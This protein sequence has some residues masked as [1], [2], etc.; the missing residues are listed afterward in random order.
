MKRDLRKSTTAKSKE[1]NERLK[2]REVKSRQ[3]QSHHLLKVA[4]SRKASIYEALELLSVVESE[5]GSDSE[6]EVAG[7]QEDEYWYDTSNIELSLSATSPVIPPPIEDQDP[8]TW[9]N[10]NQFFPVGCI[11]SPAIPFSPVQG[12]SGQ[13]REPTISESE[14][15]PPFLSSGSIIMDEQAVNRKI[16]QIKGLAEGVLML[17]ERF[18]PETVTILDKDYYRT[19]LSSIFDK[20]TEF[21]T[22]VNTLKESLDDTKEYHKAAST[23][24]TTLYTNLKAKVIANETEVKRQM[25]KLVTESDSSRSDRSVEIEQEKLKLKVSNAKIKFDSLKKEVAKITDISSMSDHEVRESV[26]TTKEWKKELKSLQDLKEKLDVDMV[27]II[28]DDEVKNSYNEAY[29]DMVKIVTD[30]MS[31]LLLADKDL[32]LYSLADSKTKGTIQYPDSFGGKMGEDVFKFIKEFKEAVIADHVRKADE[33]KTLIKY[34]KGDAKA[35]IGQ[36]HKTLESALQQLEDNY[37]SPRLIVEKYVRDYE[38][39]FGNI[40]QWGKHGSKE[41]VDAINKTTDFI[42]NLEDL[43]TNHPGHLKGEIYSKQTLLLLTKGMPHDYTKRLNETCGHKDPYEDWFSA[44]FDI[45]EDCKCTNLSALSTGIGASKVMKDD[46]HGTNKA[47]QLSHNGHDCIKSSQCKDRWDFLGCVQLYKLIQVSER[48]A[49]LRERRACF[50]CGKSPFSVKVG[51]MHLCSWKNGKMS[52][53][54][55]GKHSSGGRCYKAA[56]MCAD[57]KDNASDVLLDWLQAQRIKFTVNMIMVSQNLGTP[58][59]YYDDLK[60]K[61]EQQEN[62]VVKSR[63]SVQNRESLQSGKSSLMM[64][65]EEIYE[66][67][68]QDMRLMRSSAKVSKIPDG[69]AIFIFCVVAGLN[70][71]VMAFIDC[72]ANCFLAKEGIPES[73][74]ISVKLSNGP[75]PLSVAGGSTTYASAEYASLLPLANGNYQAVRG[76]TLRKVTGNMPELRLS[77]AFDQIKQE[78]SNNRRIQ[79]LQVPTVIG[80]EVHMI[81]GIRY[82]S[83][84]PQ[85]VHTFPSGLTIFESKLQPAEPGA[86]ACV[87]GPVS[88]L[89]SLC[90]TI[91]TSSTLS[92]MANLIQNTGQH[93]RIDLFPVNNSGFDVSDSDDSS[94]MS[95]SDCGS[96][97][98]QSEMEKFMRLQDAG[99]DSTFKCPTCRN[100][101]SCLKGAGKE[102]LSMK[103]EYQQKIIEDSVWIDDEV[104]QAVARLAFT[105]D[106]TEGLTDNEYI[107]VRR[108][109]DVC[110]KYGGDSS[111]KDM[112]T[113]GFE[114]L[115]NRGHIL[116]Y[117]NLSDLDQKLVD[118]PGYYIPWDIAF[119]QDSMSTPA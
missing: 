55:L 107:A 84:Y 14:L 24:V 52:A 81:L 94:S 40:R 17:I 33:I 65:N 15:D 7:E 68:T 38:K 76:L 48:E 42:R 12:T 61:L 54:C 34:L 105:T 32:G 116:L 59:N 36:H 70:N 13:L 87:G 108:L 74:F 50:K 63:L 66:F 110:R 71:P 53:R 62:S 85:V 58:S 27:S 60:S 73:E 86:L 101:K 72:G 57:H 98:I 37:G 97:L 64:D 25:V 10:S 114:K 117:D 23:N 28:V 83:I 19:E 11:T 21:Q 111:V 35:S 9:S 118:Q 18:N 88:F 45:L 77:P 69:E 113:K 89:E 47:N 99:L 56:A 20:L 29:N 6:S 90:G 102:L 119:K 75:I 95:C 106:P 41:R 78:C 1:L 92:Y 100:C 104:G 39:S 79:N 51:K 103:E 4:E 91:G 93:L 26:V 49:F 46:S 5:K 82:Q 115:I 96:F 80:G 3:R 16:M 2:E 112:I 43:A 67:F 8:E 22:Q 30:T 31:T 109:N 44:I